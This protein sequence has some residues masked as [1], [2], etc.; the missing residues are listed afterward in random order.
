MRDKTR[1]QILKEVEERIKT[2]VKDHLEAFM[3]EETG[4]LSGKPSHQG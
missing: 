4:D 3:R 1:E 2:M